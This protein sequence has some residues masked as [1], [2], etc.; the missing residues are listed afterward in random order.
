MEWLRQLGSRGGPVR[1]G[2]NS[3]ERP[4]ALGNVLLGPKLLEPTWLR[5]GGGR[6][7]R[8][9]RRRN[10]RTSFPQQKLLRYL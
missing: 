1:Y 7:R 4:A 8:R 3:A 6:R 10:P 9:R 2:R 5:R